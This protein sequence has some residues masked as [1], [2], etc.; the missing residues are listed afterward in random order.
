MAN[1]IV[2]HVI[3]LSI[4]FLNDLPRSTDDLWLLLHS[5]AYI[6]VTHD[7]QLTATTSYLVLVDAILWLGNINGHL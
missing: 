7:E 6:H 2:T 4:W 1:L 3:N 5:S